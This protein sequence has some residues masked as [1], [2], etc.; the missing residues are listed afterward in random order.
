[1]CNYV[2]FFFLLFV[3]SYK[4][5]L[6]IIRRYCFN[7]ILVCTGLDSGVRTVPVENYSYLASRISYRKQ[8]AS[9]RHTA[10]LTS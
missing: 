8:Q 6:E 3:V 10:L 4:I 7:H 1:M 9:A 5:M 2:V